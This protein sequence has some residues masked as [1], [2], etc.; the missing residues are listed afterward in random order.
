MSITATK[1]AGAGALMA[2]GAVVKGLLA[3]QKNDSLVSFTK[4]FRVEPICMIDQSL[5]HKPYLG[6]VLQTALSVFS[7]YYLQGVSGM[8]NVGNVNVMRMFDTLNPN[9]DVGSAA[10][11]VVDSINGASGVG[12]LSMESFANTL[13]RPGKSGV[14]MESF[15]KIAKGAIA[16]KR[17]LNPQMK[18]VAGTFDSGRLGSNEKNF[19][20]AHE[21]SN[22][23]VGKLLEVTVESEGKTA[24]FPIS[25]RL[26]TAV[27]DEEVLIHILGNG[28]VANDNHERFHRWRE[29]DL[30]FWRDLVF[31][32]DL[33]DQHK[34]ILMKDKSG[35]Y[36]EQARRR[37]QNRSAGL[38]SGTPSIGSASAITVVSKD[39]IERL[40]RDCGRKITDTRF[41]DT[42][43]DHSML[44]LLFIVDP[45]YETVTIYTRDIDLPTKLSVRELKAANKGGGAD[46]GEIL[47]AY[48]LGMSPAL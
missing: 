44:M 43:F 20:A 5:E 32:Q 31:C 39:T 42:I 48:R 45:G 9:R 38:L 22:L 40:E 21:S 1:L 12:M 30:S 47:K 19:R 18:D 46:V 29:G 36:A 11:S 24:K 10:A 3:S 26:A 33:I 7:G 37:S 34:R 17:A 27:V 16:A 8:A 15:D 28:G 4:P 25:V 14:G 23:A 13:P 41:R 35:A 6:D 2:I